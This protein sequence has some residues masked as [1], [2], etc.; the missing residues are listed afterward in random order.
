MGVAAAVLSMVTALLVFTVV[1]SPSN[2][3]VPPDQFPGVVVPEPPAVTPQR[4]PTDIAWFGGLVLSETGGRVQ[5]GDPCLVRAEVFPG[6]ALG[7]V[8]VRCGGQVLHRTS[9]PAGSAIQMVDRGL[10]EAPAS[11]SG[12]SVY[13]LRYVDL[14]TR[15]GP[16]SQI[17]LDTVR[18]LLRVFT[19][20]AEAWSANIFV[21]DVSFPRWGEPME[22]SRRPARRAEMRTL[23]ARARPGALSGPVPESVRSAVC[24]LVVRPNTFDSTFNCRFTLRC[25]G[26]I[27]YGA[28]TTG[29]S[30][31]AVSGGYP[32][33][34][35]DDGPTSENN[36][37]IISFRWAERRLL[38]ADVNESGAR[39]EV[40]FELEEPVEC[41]AG[42]RYQTTMVDAGGLE[43]TGAL[44]PR[45]DVVELTWSREGAEVGTERGIMAHTCLGGSFVIGQTTVEAGSLTAGR[46]EG[47]YGPGF[48]TFGG[49]RIGPRSGVVAA[50]RE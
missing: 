5:A 36:D 17:E 24:D 3:W 45:N 2:E 38:V 44:V 48:L 22:M 37:P 30:T 33:S 39:W 12:A 21:N 25:G 41:R 19:E 20:G 8:T 11:W 47:V 4:L 1:R 7:E 13:R 42:Q 9:D 34:A 35:D 29:Y 6:P 31:C 40:T 10:R 14:G 32:A 16:R 15:T 50:L 28:G 26:E 23:R 46:Y 49:R 18:H 43:L 27:I